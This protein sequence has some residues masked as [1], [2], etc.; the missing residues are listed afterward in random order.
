[1]LARREIPAE[2]RAQQN[3]F[4]S[5]TDLTVSALLVIVILM[6]F[7]A[8]QM[9]DVRS[10]DE[11]TAIRSQ[12]NKTETAFLEI[13]AENIE[14]AQLINQLREALSKNA[15]ASNEMD[16]TIKQLEQDLAQR[17]V[18]IGQLDLERRAATQAAELA[19]SRL[20][21]SQAE[22]R[23]NAEKI[24]AELVLA[25][26][27]GED[28]ATLIEG[29]E[30]NNEILNAEL[31]KVNSEYQKLQKDFDRQSTTAAQV[32]LQLQLQ[33]DD[34]QVQN[35]KLA[36][37]LETSGA[38]LASS[39]RT[40]AAERLR[41]ANAH[42]ELS[43]VRG[44]LSSEL[45]IS[46]ELN[47]TLNQTKIGLDTAKTRIEMQNK[48]ILELTNLI[49]TEKSSLLLVS[50]NLNSKLA[51]LNGELSGERLKL[52]V[53]EGRSKTLT[54]I[55]GELR[56]TLVAEQKKAA[57]MV[58]L[59]DDARARL[60]ITNVELARRGEEISQLQAELKAEQSEYSEALASLSD[61]IA[62]LQRDLKAVELKRKIPQN[63]AAVLV[64]ITNEL[65]AALS[66]AQDTANTLRDN[67]AQFDR[68]LASALS[69][70]TPDRQ[71]ILKRISLLSQ[72]RPDTAPD[73]ERL[74]A[75]LASALLEVEILS[76]QNANLKAT[77]QT[78]LANSSKIIE[79]LRSK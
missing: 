71:I 23:L 54:G 72:D 64:G 51:E 2:T 5:M 8:T 22:S 36:K 46:Q 38:R 58:Q 37:D 57:G 41:L 32:A 52:Q 70:D 7:M 18:E 42:T 79:R 60:D 68:K 67:A 29:S 53:S 65:R 76:K 14:Q 66:A 28:L 1:M 78:L 73:P 63:Q 31:V 69:I 11:L 74:R 59:L 75:E 45:Q 12:L 21:S 50:T 15:T 47:K 27:K 33:V 25:R 13:Q 55:V 61:Q 16:K 19:Q 77:I 4:I 17:A 44:S 26:R 49:D 10:L 35:L 39:N 6:A 48:K 30:N 62:Q 40:L 34:L 56:D 20:L 43:E 9:R 24:S 3:I